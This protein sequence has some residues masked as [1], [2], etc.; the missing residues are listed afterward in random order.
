MLRLL[1]GLLSLFPKGPSADQG[2]TLPW[3]LFLI[4]NTWGTLPPKAKV[5]TP[6]V[7]PTT[8]LCLD[9]RAPIS[10]VKSWY[11]VRTSWTRRRRSSAAM[12]GS[13]Q[14]PVIDAA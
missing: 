5:R 7:H 2:R 14:S 6:H 10:S 1:F 11:V 4:L 13:A 9:T 12:Q 8:M 3:N